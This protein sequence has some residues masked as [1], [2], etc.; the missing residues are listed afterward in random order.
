MATNV[1]AV[2]LSSASNTMN[3]VI[4]DGVGPG[5]SFQVQGPNGI[6]AVVC[7]AGKKPGDTILV[8]ELVERLGLQNSLV[9][10]VATVVAKH[11]APVTATGT[12]VLVT[13]VV[14]VAAEQEQ[15]F[16]TVGICGC[17]NM[18]DCG[19]ACCFNWC[20]CV[21]SSCVCLSGVNHAVVKQGL[22]ANHDT[23]DTCLQDL[24]PTLHLR[25]HFGQLW[26]RP[27]SRMGP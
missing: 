17:C 21:V 5:A 27:H 18:E 8:N 23:H 25:F 22:G 19:P 3:V 1:A 4:P 26:I 9:S 12:A 6:I 20:V 2:S 10:A 15:P 11:V 13:N 14:G 16:W 24:L 7:P